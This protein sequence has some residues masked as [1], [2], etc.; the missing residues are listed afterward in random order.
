M[1]TIFIDDQ[2]NKY[3]KKAWQIYEDSFPEEEKRTLTEHI[4]L[5]DKKSF[6]MLCYVED[7]ITLAIL[8]YWH[9]G[10]YTYLEHFAVN[11]IL[12]GRSYGSRILQEFINNHQNIILE[13]EPI[14][15]KLTQKRLD[16]YERFDFKVNQHTHFQVPFR[17]NAQEL[18]LIFL[19]HKKALPDDKYKTL[20]QMML[21][22]MEYEED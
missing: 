9:I 14:V 3:F 17:K 18:Q 16:F 6:K 20:Y 7:E 10:S 11:S 15:D 8:F 19:S 1:D 2:N 21:Q 12:R 4:K 13:I 22:E 5:F